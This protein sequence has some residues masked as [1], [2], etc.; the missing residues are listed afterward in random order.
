[1]GAQSPHSP[2][3]LSTE[4]GI[5]TTASGLPPR[6][7]AGINRPQPPGTEQGWAEAAGCTGA[8]GPREEI[9]PESNFPASVPWGTT[10][11]AGALEGPLQVRDLPW[12]R[13]GAWAARMG[14]QAAPGF[15]VPEAPR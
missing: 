10:R 4:S 5:E 6:A 11:P 2:L 9:P 12:G 14:S 1:M 7:A 3:P 8:E 13:E 15:P